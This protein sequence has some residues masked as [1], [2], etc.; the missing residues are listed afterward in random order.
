MA[1]MAMM[2]AN[3]GLRD[4]VR[5]WI[6]KGDNKPVGAKQL[7]DALP[8]EL[9]AELKG[10]KSSAE[11]D[12]YLAGCADFLPYFFDKLTPD[13]VLPDDDGLRSLAETLDPAKV[14]GKATAGV[15]QAASSL[16]L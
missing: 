16:G 9:L 15:K 5:S 8:D 10:D 3:N 11:M 12:K 2:L 7:A 1:S 14:A 4:E 13:G 6:K